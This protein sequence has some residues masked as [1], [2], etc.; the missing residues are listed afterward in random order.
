VAS[1]LQVVMCTPLVPREIRYIKGLA[2]RVE[3]LG[4][5]YQFGFPGRLESLWTRVGGQWDLSTITLGGQLGYIP[6]QTNDA[7]RCSGLQKRRQKPPD[8]AVPIPVS[9]LILYVE[10]AILHRDAARNVRNMPES[11]ANRC[12]SSPTDGS[13]NWASK[14]WPY[15]ERRQIL[16][17]GQGLRK[18]EAM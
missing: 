14:G 4:S 1:N 11:Q 17:N 5:A 8:L 10:A 6:S 9:R 13:C 2:L 15:N 18:D 7:P 3:S 12:R 16:R